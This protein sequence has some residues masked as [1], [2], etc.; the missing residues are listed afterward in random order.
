MSKITLSGNSSGTGTLLI[1][2]PNTNSDLVLNLPTTMGTN[3]GSSVVTTDAAGNLGLGVAP[4]AWGSGIKALQIGNYGALAVASQAFNIG[5]NYYSDGTNA[6]YLNTAPAALYQQ[7]NSVHAWY[8]APSGTAGAAISFVQAMTLDASGNLVIG[9]TTALSKLDVAVGASGARRFFANYDDSIITIKGAN[10][11]SNPETLR[12]VAD[13]IRF[14]TGTTGSGT[15][16]ARIDSSGNLLV[17]NT[18][19]GITNSLST[20]IETSGANTSRITVNHSSIAGSSNDSN[21]IQFGYGG[22]LT[23]R[24]VQNSTSSVSYVTSSDYRLKEDIAPM[25]GAL[26]KV[27]LLKPCSYKWKMDGSDG[28]GF[29]AHELAEVVSECVSGEKDAINEDGSIKPQG[30]DTSFLVATL[31]AAIQELHAIVD[32]Q[33]AEIAT[34]KGKA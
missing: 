24:I 11:S 32:A 22:S 17:G 29:I 27:A 21:F 30:I 4:S 10:D 25:T 8:T 12:I 7:L 9:S 28:Q 5:S 18:T 34:L 31:T 1:A 16:R 2:A 23:G 3:N 14:N 26:A 19:A 15:E 20:T 13:N 33:G 6:R